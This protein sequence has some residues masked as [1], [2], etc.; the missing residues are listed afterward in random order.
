MENIMERMLTLLEQMR[1]DNRQ[2]AIMIAE[3]EEELA[4]L[5]ARNTELAAG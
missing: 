1:E 3:M 2:R 5:R 4:Q